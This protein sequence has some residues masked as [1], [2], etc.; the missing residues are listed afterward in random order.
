MS[1]RVERLGFFGGLSANRT[2]LVPEGIQDADRGGQSEAEDPGEV[3][4]R[5]NLQSL[6]SM[7]M[8]RPHAP[9]LR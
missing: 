9:R 7:P 4:H 6:F 8:N 2:Q 5:C 1:G 3:P